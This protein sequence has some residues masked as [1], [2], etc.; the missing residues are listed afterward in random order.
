MPSFFGVA[1]GVMRYLVVR[2]REEP[3]EDLVL[4][5]IVV[6]DVMCKV[7]I[8]QCYVTDREY[9]LEVDTSPKLTCAEAPVVLH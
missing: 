9:S 8:V 5:R 6:L 1:K 4:G 2:W 3:T 7:Y